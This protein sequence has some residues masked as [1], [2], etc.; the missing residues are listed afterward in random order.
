MVIIL[1]SDSNY[2]WSI[3]SQFSRKF[4]LA[5]HVHVYKMYTMLKIWETMQFTRLEIVRGEVLMEETT[6]K[7]I[8]PKQWSYYSWVCL[9]FPWCYV[10]H[11]LLLIEFTL[12]VTSLLPV[13][14]T[15]VQVTQNA[16]DNPGLV[17]A[18]SSQYQDNNMAYFT[19][20][21]LKKWSLDDTIQG[22]P[23]LSHNGEKQ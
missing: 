14:R 8:M 7:L 20:T 22:F 3:Y 5:K 1:L 6:Q 9:I 15:R 21:Y 10:W 17:Q 2:R 11:C 23:W 19:F 18:T 12:K 4:Q 13:R 16:N